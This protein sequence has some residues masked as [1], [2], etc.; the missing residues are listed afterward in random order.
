[1]ALNSYM[2][3]KYDESHY[4]AKIHQ[5]YDSVGVETERKSPV[6]SI[7]DNNL[8]IKKSGGIQAND[9]KRTCSQNGGKRRRNTTVKFETLK[10][11]C[12]LYRDFAEGNEWYYY[13]EL[14]LI[15]TNMVNMEKGKS[16][17]LKILDSPENEHC[18]SYHE[19]NWKPILN[20]I[21]DMNYKPM[22]CNKC[23]HVKDCPHYKNMICTI[24]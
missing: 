18:T 13:P 12:R 5:F 19:R 21:I 8:V 3:D 24:D 15:A 1:M 22:S 4:T 17:F 23:P 11:R 9:V 16:E 7:E 10:E 14:F 20:T 2:F 6:F